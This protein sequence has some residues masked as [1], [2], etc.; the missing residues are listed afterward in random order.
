MR[1]RALLRTATLSLLLA[2]AGAPAALAQT[3]VANPRADAL[4]RRA[5]A[6]GVRSSESFPRHMRRL[7]DLYL[8]SAALRSYADPLKI[9]S[10]ERAAGLLMK[11]EPHRSR[12][13]LEQAGDIAYV[14]KDVFQAATLYTDAAWVVVSYPTGTAEEVQAAVDLLQLARALA[15]DPAVSTAQR[16]AI[17]TRIDTAAATVAAFQTSST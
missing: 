1:L 6:S 14:R 17:L 2:A 9:E 16:T 4:F 13:L 10:L 15:E 12:K 7:A 3:A 5:E 8:K 11:L